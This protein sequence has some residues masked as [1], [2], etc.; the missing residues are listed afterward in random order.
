MW[1]LH[2]KNNTEWD[3]QD[4]EHQNRLLKDI[5]YKVI[6]KVEETKPA[7]D[8]D[9]LSYAE[10][11][12]IAKEKGLKYNGIKKVELIESLKEGE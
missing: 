5:D 9:T 11:Q 12:A 1:F 6:E 3:I 7:L 4:K 2:I 10:I 8:Y